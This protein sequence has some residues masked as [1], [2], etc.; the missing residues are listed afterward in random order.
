MSRRHILERL[1][2]DFG[3]FY[4]AGRTLHTA[5]TRYQHLEIIESREF[6]HVLLLDGVTQV[7]T[8]NEFLYHEPMVHPALTCHPRSQDVLVIG[9]GDGGILRE[10]LRYNTVRKAVMAE[11]D[12]GVVDFCAK[13]LPEI[14]CGAFNDPRADIR[15]T[16][17]R[18]FVEQT[19]ER[20]D[21]VIMDM[22][23]PFGPSVMLYTREFFQAV[24][25]TFNDE[26]GIFVMHTE[27]PISRQ[28]TFQQCLGTLKSVF[29]YQ[30]T[31]YLYV[32][33]YATMWSVTVSSDKVDVSSLTADEITERLRLREVAGLQCYTGATHHSMLTAMPFIQELVDRVDDV[34]I[35]TDHHPKVLDEIDLNRVTDLRLIDQTA[36]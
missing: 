20:F 17:G 15:I 36:P 16:D 7:T 5:K 2:P 21:V 30:R 6:G 34:P 25:R 12:G 9:G 10:V 14:S 24:K 4:E 35:I 31:F 18:T 11:L 26:D 28:K 32:H 13:H 29:R 19:D 1:T 23:D 33:M 22:T 27:S 8:R 3:F